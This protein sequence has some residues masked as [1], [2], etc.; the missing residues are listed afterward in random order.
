M[1]STKNGKLILEAESAKAVGD[2]KQT[3]V[4]GEKSLLWDAD[5]S[6]YGKVPTGQTLSYEFRTDEGGAYNIALHSARVKSVMNASDRFENGKERTDT[7]NDAYVS[8]INAQTGAVV[9]KPTKLFTGLGSSD[10]DLKWG[11]TFDANHKKSAAQV[12]L[13]ANTEYRLEITGRSDGYAL[14]RITLSNDG[15]LRDTTS[16]E[17]SQ[18]GGSSPSPKPKPKPTPT[19]GD[20]FEGSLASQF[21]QIIFHFDGN[22]NDKDDIAALPMAAAITASADQ[23]DKMT[24]FYGNNLSEPN[25]N[26]QVKAMRASAELAEKLGI[27]AH[28]YQDGINQTTNKLVKILDSG[29]KVLA[30]EGG[31]MEAIYRALEQT[32]PKNRGNV[33]LL[34]HSSWN[35]N[36]AAGSRPGGGKPRTWSDLLNFRKIASQIAP[37]SGFSTARSAT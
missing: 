4:D 7:G 1:F 19:P 37:G 14:D 23:Q 10:K 26:S 12:N 27:D 3:T 29:Q 24:F 13:A 6:S 16:P 34:S 18:G 25:S 32:S 36:R 8:L 31:P 30:I 11:T 35:E 33:T 28:S 21:D 17:S 2:W 5:R 22:N 15:V 20:P 9:Q